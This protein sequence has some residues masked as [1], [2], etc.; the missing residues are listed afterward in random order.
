MLKIKTGHTYSYVKLSFRV[1]LFLAFFYL[2]PS[3][4]VFSAFYIYPILQEKNGQNKTENQQNRNMAKT[5]PK[6][7]KFMK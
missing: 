4:A 3:S 5:E 1:G 6:S 7:D 2:R